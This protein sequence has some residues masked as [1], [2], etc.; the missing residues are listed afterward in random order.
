MLQR[1]FFIFILLS[2]AYESRAQSF[3]QLYD[4]VGDNFSKAYHSN[5]LDGGMILITKSNFWQGGRYFTIFKTL[6]NGDLQWSKRYEQPGNCNVSNIVQLPDSSY[7]FCFV[8]LNFP[9]KYYISHLDKFGALI[10][11]RSLTPPP[12]YIVAFDPYCIAK[13]DGN[14]YVQADLHDMTN[15]MFGWHL[16]EVD[17]NG[18]IIFSTCYNGSILKC[19]GRGINECANGDLLL[20]GYQRDSVSLEFGPVI[21]R[22]DSDGVMLWSKLYLDTSTSIAGLS[23]AEASNGNIYVTASHTTPGNEVIRLETDANGNLLRTREYGHATSPMSPYNSKLVENNATVIYGTTDTGSFVMKL[24]SLG[25]IVAAKR[26]SWV[27]PGKIQMLSAGDYTFSGVDSQTNHALLFSTDISVSSCFGAPFSIDTGSIQFQTL[28]IPNSY[29]VQLFDTAFTLNDT[30]WPGVDLKICG[31]VGIE[32]GLPERVV[33]LF[34]NPANEMVTI[35]SHEQ[36]TR[37][38]LFDVT[39][40]QLLSESVYSD[41]TQLNVSTFP[42]GC[43]MI[44]VHFENHI[45]SRRLIIE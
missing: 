18:N 44:R 36:I 6:A 40:R 23:I 9:E 27:V 2:T 38:E 45:E 11:C 3:K 5:T 34:P 37:I 20:V 12:N 35:Q 41:A 13:A 33:Q 8:E 10:Y 14:V 42:A 29:N 15:G 7:F 22:V 17:I 24:D 19:L 32:E 1:L 43:Y 28:L 4:V 21:T 31:P 30:L 39:A 16:F 26:F 25:N